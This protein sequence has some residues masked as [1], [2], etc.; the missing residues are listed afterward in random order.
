MNYEE[1]LD[2]LYTRLP[3]FHFVGGEA[4][5]PG[6]DK[7]IAMMEHF[8]NPHRQY[9]TIHIGGTNGKGSVSHMLSAILQ[10][11][12]YK[13]GL[14]TSPHLVDF[15]ERIRVN[16]EMIDKE[17]VVDFVS[18]NM[19]Y[20]EEMQPSFF[21]ATMT[22]SFDYF[23]NQK[24]D[25]AIVEVGLGGRLDSTNII[26]P[27]LTVITNVSQDHEQFLGETLPEIAYEKAGI[28]KTGV[29]VVIG[30]ENPVS[31]P[32]FLAKAEEMESEMTFA[33]ST[34]S[35]EFVEYSYGKMIVESSS[36]GKL[37][38]GLTGNFQLKN[39]ATLLEAVKQLRK[40]GFEISDEHI[41]E[42]VDRVLELSGLQGRWQV[43]L[44][45]PTVI[46]DSGHNIAAI[47]NI[48]KQLEAQ[49]KENLRI[50][51]GMAGDKNVESVLALLPKDAH[52]YFTAADSPRS[53][54]ADLLGEKAT[55]F[56]L[57][58]SVYSS[59]NEAI[60]TALTD[61]DDND[62]VF[63]GGSNFVVGEALE[64]WGNKIDK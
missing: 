22:L 20:L 48:V 53:Y 19:E 23:A 58:G 1:T 34:E 2:Y 7:S 12:G 15:G 56:G 8:G 49:E 31:A 10:L 27:E 42:G 60:K 4:F 40:A 57:K 9:K 13:T 61:A 39:L 11:A 18:S 21:E 45:N 5:K 47:E 51:I 26:K 46:M 6:L 24:V 64:G 17:F 59:V 52:Y 16:G 28:I 63:I 32:V 14:Y 3:V 44:E 36:F 54:K 43:L 41:S 37:S 29:P 50:V 33:D 55:Q 25:V 35:V 62:L 30:E 38:S